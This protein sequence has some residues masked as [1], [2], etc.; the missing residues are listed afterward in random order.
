MPISLAEHSMRPW[1]NMITVQKFFLNKY[2]ELSGLL[3]VIIIKVPKELQLNKLD[4]SI[5]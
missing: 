3:Q 5:K 4:G 1:S 2:L